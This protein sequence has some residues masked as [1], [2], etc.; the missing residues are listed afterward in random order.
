M[1]EK[2]LLSAQNWARSVV[3]CVAPVEVK[4]EAQ[5]SSQ[6]CY[7]ATAQKLLSMNPP[8]CDMEGLILKLK[9]QASH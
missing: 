4:L 3:A 7:L 8:P 2:R 6:K 1:L 5:N 9:V